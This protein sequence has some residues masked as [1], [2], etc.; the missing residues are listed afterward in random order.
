MGATHTSCTRGTPYRPRVGTLAAP[1]LE[2]PTTL[3]TMDELL[4]WGGVWP[5]NVAEKLAG[6]IRAD[7]LNVF[8]LHA[9]V[10]GRALAPAFEQFLQRLKD[11]GVRF[12]RLVD[13]AG[14]TL[15]ACAAGARGGVRVRG[16]PGRRGGLA[17]LGPGAGGE[18]S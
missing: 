4:G 1:L 7:R 17:G 2:I 18:G 15:T 12:L 11:Q 5:E 3:P 6:M 14:E 13:A 10:E 8:T 16:G 9:E